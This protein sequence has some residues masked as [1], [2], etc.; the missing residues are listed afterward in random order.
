MEITYYGHSCFLVNIGDFRVLFDPFISP[1]PKAANIDINTIEADYILLSHGHNDHMADLEAIAKRTGAT[2]IANFEIVTWLRKK[3]L[4][5]TVAMNIGG[6]VTM[7]FAIVKMVRAVHSSQLPDGSYGGAPAGFIIE[8]GESTFYYSGDTAL[9]LDMK[10]IPDM[11]HID[12]AFISLGDTY[13]M[14][15]ED[16]IVA[17]NFVGTKKI[18]GMHFDTWPDIEID[19]ETSVLMASRNERELILMDIGETIKM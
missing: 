2:V 12:F 13:T 19:H 4:E 14:D 9:H 18:I 11:N 5:N 6:K 17:S 8:T 7:D 1:N 3:G 15:V 16:A 10:L